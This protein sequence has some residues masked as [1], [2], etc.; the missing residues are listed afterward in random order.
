V[1]ID[2]TLDVLT[3][4]VERARRHGF[5]QTEF[6]RQKSKTLR[7]SERAVKEKDKADARAYTFEMVNHFL[8]GEAMPGRD[9]EFALTQKYLPTITLEEVNKLVE[10][11]TSRKDRV[12]M[13]SGAARD[14]MPNEQQLLAIVDEVSG[15][16]IKAYEEAVVAE[17]LM[18]KAPE[19]GKVTDEQKIDAIG[20]TVWTLSNGAKVV[21]KPTD[22]K[23]D[24]VMLRAISP[25]GTSLA[26]KA[27]Y[28]SANSSSGIVSQAGVGDHDTA[29]LRK[30]LAGKVA[31][32]SPYI[33]ELEEGL[34][35][36]ASP[37]DLETMMQMLHLT[38]V[39]PR[40]D[41]EAFEAWKGS[42]ATFV[43]NR[44]LNPQAVFYDELRAFTDNN[45]PRSKPLTMELLDTIDLEVAQ[46]FYQDRFGDAGDFTFVLVGNIDLAQAK[47]LSETYLASLPS[48]G[49]KEKWKDVKKT[50]PRGTKK[51]EVTKGQDPKSSVRITFHG[52]AKWTPETEDDLE[53]LSEILEIRLREV[54]REEMGGVYGAFSRGD[55]ERRPKQ[56]YT[57]SVGFG[58]APEN[59]VSLRKA[60]FDVIASIKKEGIG[61]DYISKVKELRRRKLE[62]DLEK[63]NFWMNELVD[64]Y[65]YGTDPSTIVEDKQK[66]VD[67]VSS[68]IVQAAAKR[69]LGKNRV[70]GVLMPEAS[71]AGDEGA[72]SE[73][74]EKGE[75][76]A[77]AGGG[78]K[79]KKGEKK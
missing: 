68:K 36:S 77:K 75:K 57:Y 45:H 69:Y 55:F 66:G 34:W 40:K 70:E 79:A 38:F 53:Q 10:D 48:Q 18:A 1:R 19:P 51:L 5:L 65:R 2:K 13:A 31:R 12:V 72:K 4:E 56:R 54:L 8:E 30:I 9:A 67:R 27:K 24:E 6:D 46:E 22:F 16:D 15:R 76:G 26:G 64:H 35:G 39:A 59:V 58:C 17:S 49:R 28:W 44:D 60:V 3:T 33:R 78:E 50:H 47:K 25:G 62:T 11:W 32:V 73:K 21:V 74:G 43:K 71:A 29:T 7:N 23:N 41:A 14:Q 61:D 63:N 37:Q 52:K 42:T 20:V